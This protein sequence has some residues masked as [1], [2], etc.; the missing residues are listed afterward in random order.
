MLRLSNLT[1]KN[2]QNLSGKMKNYTHDWFS[3][4]IPIH[5]EFLMH[6]EGKENLKFLEIGSFEG[7]STNWFLDNVLTDKTSKIYC[8]DTFEGSYEHKGLDLSSLYDIFSNNIEYKKEQVEIFR[9]KS[10]EKLFDPKIRKEKFDFIFIDGCHESREV[11]EDAILSWELLKVNGIM[12]FDDVLWGDFQN[13]PTKTPRL[14]VEAF[15]QTYKEYLEI[16]YLGYQV[17]IRKIK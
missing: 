15:L 6:L 13:N 8:I 7:L 11:L 2:N 12:N 1:N 4:Y 9:G 17:V 3:Y 10:S 14:A 5:Q 16:L